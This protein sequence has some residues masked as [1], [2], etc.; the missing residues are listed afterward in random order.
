MI[1]AAPLFVTK[2]RKTSVDV[3]EN[4]DTAVEP[5]KPKEKLSEKMEYSLQ[6][7]TRKE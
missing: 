2:S 5:A 7:E 1:E 6:P 3:P 4:N